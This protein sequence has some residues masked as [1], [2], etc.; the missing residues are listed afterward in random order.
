[1]A[2]AD[3][4]PPAVGD[5]LVRGAHWG[6]LA[7]IA[8]FGAYHLTNLVLTA[9]LSGRF[10]GFDDAEEMPDLG[11][12][13][14]LAFVPNLMLG[15][16]PVLAARRWGSFR[17]LGVLPNLRDI[18]IGL[19]CGGFALLAGYLTNL[20]LLPVFGTDLESGNPLAGLAQ[21]V[22]DHPVW[23]ALAA[24]IVVLVAPLSEEVLIRGA[25]WTGLAAHRVPQWAVLALTAAVFAQLHG[26]PSRTLALFVQGLAIGA[27]RLLSGRTGSSVVA[28]AANNLPPALLLLGAP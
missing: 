13:L 22:G 9:V 18:K 28:H 24:L 21:G 14:L 15:L 8:G 17:E 4:N 7:F 11:P 16:A 2:Q 23:L 12:L 3:E 6:L 27:A 20:L 5:G 26:E 1:M 25:L 10:T 19:A